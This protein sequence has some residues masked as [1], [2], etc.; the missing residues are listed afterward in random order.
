MKI[1]RSGDKPG[2]GFIVK[3]GIGAGCVLAAAGIVYYGCQVRYY[4]EHFFRGTKIN[5]M[6]CE[7]LTVD[8]AEEL[9]REKVEDYELQ[10]QFR[11]DCTENI[12]GKDIDYRYVSDGSVEQLMEEQNPFFWMSGIFKE[13]SYQVGET[14]S[15]DE[16][17]LEAQIDGLKVMKES[18]QEPPVDAYVTFKDKEFVIVDEIYGS[19]I[20]REVL[21]EKV[22]DAVSKSIRMLEAEES[23]VYVMPK[24]T[25]ESEEIIREREQLNDLVA[26]S[27]TYQ[28]P[29]G[30]K[31][32]DGNELRTWLSV[33]KNGNYYNDAEKFD[34]QLHKYVKK[35][36]KEVDTLGKERPFHTTS[37]LDV[38]VKG[39]N[40]GWKIDQKK[41][42]KELRKNIK[43][44]KNVSREPKYSSREKYKKNNGLGD[45]YIEVNLTEQHLYYYQDGKIVVESPIVSGTMVSS[46]YTPPGVYFL[47]YKMRDKVLRGRPLP[48]GT[49]SYES[50][51]SFWMPFNGG[52]GLH[53]ANW[54]GS[55]GGSIYKYS[56]SHGCIN[57]PYKKAKQVYERIDKEVPIVCVYNDGYSLHG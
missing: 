37:G 30:E 32:L 9:I 51:V 36:A 39:G 11:S 13:H 34:E 52:I 38:T 46:R 5:Q 18:A 25:S 42:R 41:E 15:F 48:D 40:Y 53:D 45:T 28:L 29:R 12:S 26:V 4:K 54:R 55:F 19:T 47:T 6:E 49:P 21:S 10:L 44:M 27:I 33:D 14:V 24:V 22:H 31:I 43:A 56:G 50:P 1:K 57:M 3:A 16:E 35:L 23:G 2:K 20:K 8:E 17:K 7:N